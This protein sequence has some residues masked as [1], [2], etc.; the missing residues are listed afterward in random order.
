MASLCQKHGTRQGLIA[1][2][3]SDVGVGKVP[4]ADGFQVLDVNQPSNRTSIQQSFDFAGVWSVAHDMASGENDAGL[5]DSPTYRL[6]TLSR[7]CT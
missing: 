1:P 4:E 6:A 2:V 7:G 3:P 5:V